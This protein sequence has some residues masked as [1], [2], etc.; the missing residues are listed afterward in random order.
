VLLLALLQVGAIAQA[1]ADAR[2]EKETP[3]L[4]RAR[5]LNILKQIREIVDIKYYDEAFNGYDFEAKFKAAEERIE[6]LERNAD[7]Y[8]TIADF[9]LG[10]NDSHTIFYP[11][12]L[13]YRVEY[14]FS[15]SVIGDRCFVTEVKPGSDAAAMG[16]KAGDQ[17][18][19]FNGQTPTRN[20]LWLIH[21][22]IY[23][24]EPQED[25]KLKVRDADRKDREVSFKS[26][27]ISPEERKKERKK[28]KNDEQAKPYT[29]VAIGSDITA[30]KLRTF[31]VEKSVID[32]MMKEV[33]PR[34]KLILDLRGNAGGYVDTVIHLTGSFFDQDVTIG[35][36]KLRRKT[37]ERIAKGRRDNAYK[38]DLMVLIDSETGSASEVFSRVIQIE[39]R[40]R[41]AGDVSM[42]GVMT[43][44][45][46][47]IATETRAPSLTGG[48]TPYYLSKLSISIADLI[49]AD[50]N[51]LEGRGV[52][53][54]VRMTPGQVAIYKRTDPL[55]SYAAELMGSPITD[56][57]AGKF[58]FLVPKP[59]EAADKFDD[60][61]TGK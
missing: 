3:K 7:I 26:K 6:T 10:L 31:E 9:V 14:G 41:V 2:V 20:N 34:N 53:P 4:N 46:Y 37:K 15:M 30:C 32:K 27:F 29:C 61:I 45:R 36:E 19:H 28:R 51:R 48:S 43:S 50:G 42:G 47:G 11:P 58:Y 55:L 52:V 16:L 39:K 23:A 60:E 57:E 18:L 24:L 59:E 5:G 8:R 21:Y 25:I 13:R 17:I 40:G 54:D 44:L 38:G 22:I 35:T 12:N 56:E 49:M 1:P 33:M